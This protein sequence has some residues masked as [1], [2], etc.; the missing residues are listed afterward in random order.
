MAFTKIQRHSNH[1]V[2]VE[3]FIATGAG[4]LSE[5][6]NLGKSVAIKEVRLHL[7]AATTASE[8]FVVAVDS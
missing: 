7:N 3:A 5:T 8:N 1:L 6:L 2:N 4:A